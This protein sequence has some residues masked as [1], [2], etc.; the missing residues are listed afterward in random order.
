MKIDYMVIMVLVI[1]FIVIGGINFLCFL[2]LIRI[3]IIE[4][5]ARS[6]YFLLLFCTEIRNFKIKYSSILTKYLGTINLIEYLYVNA[7]F[8]NYDNSTNA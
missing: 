6:F 4:T 8:E 5:S 1:P 7:M 2:F 3:V